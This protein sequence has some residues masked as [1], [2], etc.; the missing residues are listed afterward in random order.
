MTERIDHAAEA[1]RLVDLADMGYGQIDPRNGDMAVAQMVEN[2]TLAVEA[3]VH[4][5]LAL[6]EQQRL[7]NLIALSGSS[8]G[9]ALA[10]A[11]SDALWTFTEDD[12]WSGTVVIRPEVREALGL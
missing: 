9:G 7:S 2:Q 11:A 10:Q 1:R 4:A 8:H 12:Q 3:Q 5:T 6:A